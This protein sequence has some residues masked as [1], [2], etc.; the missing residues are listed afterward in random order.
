[1]FD[2]WVGKIPWRREWLP[3]PIFLPGESPWTE[4]PGGLKSMGSQ[5]VKHDRVTRHIYNTNSNI[6][7][8]VLAIQKNSTVL[9]TLLLFYV[10]NILV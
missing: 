6:Y 10:R 9:S 5:T 7:K 2:H 4:E 3:I 8:Y 1:M